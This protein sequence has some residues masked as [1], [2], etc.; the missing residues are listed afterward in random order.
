MISE[1]PK[2]VI[3]GVEALDELI[4]RHIYGDP[5]P[6]NTLA[7]S[8]TGFVHE[9]PGA[10]FTMRA[11]SWADCITDLDDVDNKGRAP[12]DYCEKPECDSCLPNFT[13][14][15]TGLKLWWY[16]HARRIPESNQEISVADWTEIEL[17]CNDW[18]LKQEKK[19][20]WSD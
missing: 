10:P 8:N 14:P 17:A 20:A 4:A 3:R 6:Y 13:F 19:E 18:V 2:Y 1:T 9:L 15:E 5:D 12:Y 7:T 16:K 11:Y